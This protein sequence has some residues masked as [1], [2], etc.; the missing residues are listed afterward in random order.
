MLI[1]IWFSKRNTPQVRFTIQTCINCKELFECICFLCSVN[2]FGALI[3]I[4]AGLAGKKQK[5]IQDNIYFY[6]YHHFS[7]T[8]V[9]MFMRFCMCLKWIAHTNIVVSGLF[10]VNLL[11]SPCWVDLGEKENKIYLFSLTFERCLWLWR[12]RCCWLKWWIA[13]ALLTA[14]HKKDKK[15]S[16]LQ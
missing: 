2:N 3:C 13:R 11:W 12:S 7:R 15:N 9:A 4:L 6:I 8:N 10:V 14:V 16:V 1:I 5:Y